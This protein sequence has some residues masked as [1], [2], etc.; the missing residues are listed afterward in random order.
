MTR[1]HQGYHHGM[2]LDIDLTRLTANGKS[3]SDDSNGME[4][5]EASSPVFQRGRRRKVHDVEVGGVA[6]QQAWPS[7]LEI[8]RVDR[9]GPLAA[10][11]SPWIR[12]KPWGLGSFPP[13]RRPID[14]CE[15]SASGN[16]ECGVWPGADGRKLLLLAARGSVMHMTQYML[17]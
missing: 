13:H 16:L 14:C 7:T 11:T 10:A 9:D 17:S 15:H 1:D 6:N 2:H 12:G 3:C 4:I 8:A 5:H